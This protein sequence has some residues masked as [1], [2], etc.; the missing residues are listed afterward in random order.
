MGRDPKRKPIV[1]N[2]AQMAKQWSHRSPVDREDLSHMLPSINW[3]SSQKRRAAYKKLD[4]Q[5]G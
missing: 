1:E 2:L 5:I 4:K 3:W